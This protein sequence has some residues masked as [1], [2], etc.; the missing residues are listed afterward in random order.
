M[1][2]DDLSIMNGFVWHGDGETARQ[3]MRFTVL[4][5]GN[6][7]NQT[8]N[9]KAKDSAKDLFF[10]PVFYVINAKEILTL[11]TVFLKKC[12]YT[13]QNAYRKLQLPDT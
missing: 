2:V 9:K 3:L 13:F 12:L 6:N 8:K 10:F 11:F 1:S 5:R 7:K 4:W